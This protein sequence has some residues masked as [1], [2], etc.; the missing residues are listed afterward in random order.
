M[1]EGRGLAAGREEGE[2]RSRPFS[3]C[4]A[5]EDEPGLGLSEVQGALAA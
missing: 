3:T 5:A 2:C 4:E 1:E